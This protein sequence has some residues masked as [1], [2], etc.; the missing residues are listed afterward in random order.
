MDFSFLWVEFLL[1]MRPGQSHDFLCTQR[2]RTSFAVGSL[3]AENTNMFYKPY[4]AL[5]QNV[6]PTYSPIEN[7]TPAAEETWIKST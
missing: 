3:F 2:I 6:W 5:I 1:Y 7:W 4:I